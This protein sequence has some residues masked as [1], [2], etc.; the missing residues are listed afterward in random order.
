M[1]YG[2]FSIFR[3]EVAKAFSKEFGEAYEI[4]LNESI[5]KYMFGTEEELKKCDK[6][7][8][9]YLKTV[10]I[11]EDIVDFLFQTDC[12]GKIGYKTARKISDLCKQSIF[13]GKFG[14][15]Y[16]QRSMAEMAEIFDDAVK[17]RC[18]VRWA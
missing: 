14:Y 10:N 1:G 8:E 12:G 9:D 11:E 13:K 16:D 4:Y 18:N 17:H 15:V 3:R 6:E 5:R 2:S 7:F